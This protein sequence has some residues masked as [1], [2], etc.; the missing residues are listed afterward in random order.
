[1]SPPE[2]RDTAV[3]IT[4]ISTAGKAGNATFSD[5]F[6]ERGDQVKIAI[7]RD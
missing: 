1:M 2:S 7:S 4:Q 6:S 5:Q 3:N